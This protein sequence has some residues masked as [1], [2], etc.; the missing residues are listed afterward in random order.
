MLR[1][2]VLLKGEPLPQAEVACSL[3]H[4]FFKDLSVFGCIHPSLLLAVRQEQA[5][6]AVFCSI[7]TQE[8]SVYGEL[9]SFFC[10]I[11]ADNS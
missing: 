3:E 2:I 11:Y 1:V 9:G 4:V 7:H 8:S 10:I 5:L 6:S